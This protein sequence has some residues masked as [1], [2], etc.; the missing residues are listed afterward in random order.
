MLHIS[1]IC[2][3]K[4]K[5]EYWRKAEA[6]YLKRLSPFA[7]IEIIGIKEEPFGEKDDPTAIKIKEAEKIK[8]ALVGKADGFIIALDE[9]GEPFSSVRFA[10][11]INSLAG[12]RTADFVI[13]IGGP[14]G[15]SDSILKIADMTLSLSLFTFTHQMARVI[16]LE[17][18]YRAMMI[19]SGRKY[20]Y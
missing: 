10:A 13:I 14:L 1:I 19:N 2:L 16:L 4:L 17:Q 15:L 3:G 18:I 8:K 9:N 7:K 20:H 12:N 6:E 5:E 11:K